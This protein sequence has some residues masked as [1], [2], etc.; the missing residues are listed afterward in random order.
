[1]S[2]A[3]ARAAAS[4]AEAL[5]RKNLANAAETPPHSGAAEALA[6]QSTTDHIN[7]VVDY[8]MTKDKRGGPVDPWGKGRSL[9]GKYICKSCTLIYDKDLKRCDICKAPNLTFTA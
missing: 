3:E 6:Y 8:L 4:E 7:S 5:N 1:V 2:D 9:Q